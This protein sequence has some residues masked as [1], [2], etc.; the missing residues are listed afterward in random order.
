MEK[1]VPPT[2]QSFFKYSMAKATNPNFVHTLTMILTYLQAILNFR[3][4][5]LCGNID[6]VVS[7]KAV[8]APLFHAR[9]HPKYQE[10]EISKS[11]Q[12]QCIPGVYQTN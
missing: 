5:L 10:I 3:A 2:P 8:F 11:I 6:V 7:A 4:G 12:R 1:K 9:N